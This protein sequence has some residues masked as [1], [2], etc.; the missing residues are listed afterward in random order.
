MS[1]PNPDPA[2]ERLQKVL[3]RAGVASRRQ[4]EAYIQRGRIRVNGEVVEELG[5]RVDITRDVV[6]LDGT[7]LQLDIDRRYVVF[8]KPTGVVTSL[9]DDRGRRDLQDVL[10]EISASGCFR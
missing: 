6:S 8:H 5:R 10:A 4:V 1:S 3:S 2:G 7:P 9:S